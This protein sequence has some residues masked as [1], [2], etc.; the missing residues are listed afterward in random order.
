[1]KKKRTAWL[2][3]RLERLSPGERQAVEAALPALERL[4]DEGE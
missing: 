1:V 2:A 3:E 4:L